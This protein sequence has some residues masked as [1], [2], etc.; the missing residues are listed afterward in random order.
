MLNHITNAA[1]RSVTGQSSGNHFMEGLDFVIIASGY[2]LDAPPGRGC[3]MVPSHMHRRNDGVVDFI[4]SLHLIGTLLYLP[5]LG[6]DKGYP[7][8]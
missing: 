2:A 5:I 1:A 8:N 3:M 6:H 4:S 7:F